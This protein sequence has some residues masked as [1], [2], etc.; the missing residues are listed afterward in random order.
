MTPNIMR[1]LKFCGLSLASKLIA[2]AVKEGR[3]K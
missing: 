3:I 2:Q 1:N